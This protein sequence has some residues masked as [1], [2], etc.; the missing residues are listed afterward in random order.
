VSSTPTDDLTPRTSAL[1]LLEAG[2]T[3]LPTRPGEKWPPF[4]WTEYQDRRPTRE[5][6]EGW[7]AADPRRGVAL[8]M[9]PALLAVDVDTKTGGD[10]TPFMGTTPAVQHTPN[11]GFHFIYRLSDSAH[12][13]PRTGIRKG[14]DIRS[15][16]SI[17]VF[18]PTAIP[19]RDGEVRAYR[20]DD[21]GMEALLKGELPDATEVPVVR[22]LLKEKQVRKDG[23]QSDPWIASVLEH[24]ED[25]APGTQDDTL[26]RLAFW[27]AG[28][29]PYDI[30]LG[31]LTNWVLQVPLT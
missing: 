3:P 28:H 16:K 5:E 31:Q 9:G 2:L 21:G 23:G 6:I 26:N 13:Q 24:P 11:H 4:E 20:F 18:A 22:A 29:L 19:A 25:V 15:G 12:A 8:L 14:I 27:A 17:I 30:A 1:A 10:P 7:Y